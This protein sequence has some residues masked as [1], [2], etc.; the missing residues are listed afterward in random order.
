MSPVIKVVGEA[1]AGRD[2]LERVPVGD[3]VLR[4]LAPDHRGRRADAL[5]VAEAEEQLRERGE[6][7]KRQVGVGEQEGLVDGDERE[8]AHELGGEGG[9]GV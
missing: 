9:G 5:G 4:R 8:D 3:A 6:E 2:G 7:A 1:L